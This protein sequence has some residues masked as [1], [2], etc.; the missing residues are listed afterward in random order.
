MVPLLE[1]IVWEFCFQFFKMLCFAD[2]ASGIRLADCSKLAINRKNKNDVTIC[3]H[4]AIVI[5]FWLNHISFVKFKY[6]SK[7]HVNIVTGSRVMTIF[8]YRGLTGNPEI[9]SS[10]FYPISGEWGEK[11]V[12]Y[13]CKGLYIK[14]AGKT[15]L[16][17][18]QL[19]GFW[20]LFWRSRC[21]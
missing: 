6:W 21:Y 14:F 7:F 17:Y 18:C 1:A 10:E 13:S 15:C 5:F 12:H 20:W 16:R 4:D 11:A 2:A 8:L 3:R 9:P 19:S